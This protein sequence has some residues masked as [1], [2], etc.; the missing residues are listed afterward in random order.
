LS[1]SDADAVAPAPVLK[2]SVGVKFFYGLG[3]VVQSGG[4]DTALVFT[5]F[6]Y[7]AVLGLSG[8]LAGVAM[9]VSLCI[10]AIVDPLVGS[11]SDN[12]RSRWGRRLP[13]MVVSIPLVA[14]SFGLLF[15]PPGGLSELLLF[16]WLTS[17]SIAARCAV[18]LFNVPYIALGAEL[19]DGYVERSRVVV[20]RTVLGLLATVGIVLL[21]YSVFFAGKGGLERPDGYPGFGW[22]VA[23]V[24]AF[25][26]AA[27]CAGIARYAAGLPQAEVVAASM[28]RRLPGEVA[29]I[30]RNRSFRT[31]FFACLMIMVAIGLNATFNTHVNTYV[32]RLLPSDIQFLTLGLLAGTLIGVPIAP[33]LSRRLEKRSLV[34]I[35][36]TMLNIVWLVLPLLR[37][38]GL[39]APT[40]PAAIPPLMAT[41]LFAGIGIGLVL[42]A[43]PSM[44]ADAADEHEL[45]F[46][47][48]REGLYFSGLTFVGK[49]ASGLGVVVAG[50]AL[51]FVGLP[52]EAHHG[53]VSVMNE[54]ALVRLI[55]A[56]GP[57]AAILSSF[58]VL[59]MWPYAITRKAHDTISEELR[60]QRA[61]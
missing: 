2:P 32:W 25:G 58:G 61:A 7:T 8:F 46:G 30:F 1:T 24:L 55:L 37:A 49:A 33:A 50:L 52:K 36:V 41:V 26:M 29:E 59:L 40:G 57:G 16:A 20:W 27:C 5:F 14:L 47:R 17:T 44:M 43:F 6:Y 48:R 23:A 51:D 9:G 54:G 34:M 53:L 15:S 22:S 21:A 11:W 35:G 13:L 4:F 42:V 38:S 56:A 3:Q 12:I 18:S 39:Y 45:L 10:D 60:A 28:I 19:A 31:L